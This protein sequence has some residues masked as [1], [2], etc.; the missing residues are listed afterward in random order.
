MEESELSMGRQ[1]GQLPQNELCL[2]FPPPTATFLYKGLAPGQIICS[3]NHTNSLVTDRN[4][5]NGKPSGM[6]PSENTSSTKP[7][8]NK[9]NYEKKYPNC[10]ETMSDVH[11]NDSSLVRSHFGFVR[12]PEPPV[13]REVPVWHGPVRVSRPART[14]I[15][16]EKR[17][18]VDPPRTFEETDLT[19]KA[20]M[21]GQEFV[22]RLLNE[23]DPPACAIA[24]HFTMADLNSLKF[25]CKSFHE[26]L[27]AEGR[28]G[29]MLT[30]ITFGNEYDGETDSFNG[31]RRLTDRVPFWDTSSVQIVLSRWDIS[32]IM[33][34]ISLD[35]TFVDASCVDWLLETFESIKRISVRYCRMVRLG[36]F[37]TILENHAEKGKEEA[38]RLENIYI[39]YWNIPEIYT[40]VSD[41]LV[42]QA[43]LEQ[44]T[45]VAAKIRRIAQLI[46]SNVF[47]CYRNHYGEGIW[48]PDK[49]QFH[50][51]NGPDAVLSCFYPAEIILLQ[52]SLCNKMYE[53]RW[54][55]RCFQANICTFCNEY[56][57]MACDSESYAES[58]RGKWEFMFLITLD[59]YLKGPS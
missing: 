53:R 19:G 52:C 20:I 57:C 25:T 11:K 44:A 59:H 56:H 45:D 46:E 10:T 31:I 7:P 42:G 37:L 28:W 3:R 40:V 36:E 48:G 51:E 47:L 22:H 13:E 5:S 9:Q 23:P 50:V 39:D 55:F 14:V 35:Y 49:E 29:W 33:V 38:A 27:T 16:W 15:W 12:R 18:S 54:C 32:S 58:I 17:D 26:A 34:N 4:T 24:R 2:S 8:K 43:L 41:M 1:D 6:V 21:S 30:N